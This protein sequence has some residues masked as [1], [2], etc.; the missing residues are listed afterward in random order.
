MDLTS[1][2]RL[3][4]FSSKMSHGITDHSNFTLHMKEKNI[5]HTKEL[6]I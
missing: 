4:I 5:K 1:N 3:Q 2:L 6:L